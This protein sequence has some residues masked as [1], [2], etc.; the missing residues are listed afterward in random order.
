MPLSMCSVGET[1]KVKKIGG[2]AEVKQ[3]LNEIGFNVGSPVTIV[4]AINGNI[5]VQVKESRFALDRAMA[6][7]IMV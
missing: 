6:N 4:S 2:S 1:C 3:R 7:R 5:I